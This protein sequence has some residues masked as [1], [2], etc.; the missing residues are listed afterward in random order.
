MLIINYGG[1]LP[2]I[3]GVNTVCHSKEADTYGGTIHYILLSI[4]DID[5]LK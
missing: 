3:G 4:L 2:E 1:L 5:R